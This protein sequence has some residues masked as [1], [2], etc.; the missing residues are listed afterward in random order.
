MSIR[1]VLVVVAG[2]L[3]VACVYAVFL[4]RQEPGPFVTVHGPVAIGGATITVDVSV[5]T[6]DA[7]AG[8]VVASVEQGSRRAVVLRSGDLANTAVAQETPTRIRL[9]RTVPVSELGHFEDGSASLVVS[10]SRPVLFGIRHATTEVRKDVTV[11]TSPP[12]IAVVSTHHY[13]ALGG[14][15]LVVYRVDPPGSESGVIVGD[16]FYRGYPAQGVAGSPVADLRLHLAFFAVD[17]EQ[18]MSVPVRLRARDAAGNETLSPFDHRVLPA[19]FSRRRVRIDDRFLA[20]VVPAIVAATPGLDL[21]SSTPAERLQAF[22]VVNNDVRQRNRE[23]V[24]ALASGTSPEWLARG[25][26]RRLPGSQTEAPFAEHR[27]YFYRGREVDQ[28]VHLGFDLASVRG[29]A[30]AASNTGRVA[31]AGFLGIYGN[32]VVLDH[33]MGVQSLYAHLSSLE[34]ERG[35]WVERGETIGRSGATGLAGGDHV[36]FAMLVGGTPTSPVE[37]WDR[38]WV[39][40][41]VERKLRAAGVRK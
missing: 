4:I 26:F 27:T 9:T 18:N 38:H 12:V 30:V 37:W 31:L 22:L 41:R 3:A 39:E 6:H 14:A 13:V 15:E 33:G 16:R 28:Q 40:D 2:L 25:S 21:P 11:H 23:Q 34:V 24:A 10:A 35:D 19:K 17:Y 5:D 8:A 36:H 29:A 32:T 20:R 1:H 7:S